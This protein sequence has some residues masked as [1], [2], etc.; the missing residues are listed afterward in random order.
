[1]SLEYS[2]VPLYRQLAGLLREQIESGELP[3][4]R[5]I[6]SK[7]ALRQEHGVS[8]QTVDKAT[9]L[10]KAEGLVRTVPGLGL[11]VTRPEEWSRRLR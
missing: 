8:A 5:P 11:F 6:P 10:L 3:P 2:E 7:R 4:G 9:A 1:V